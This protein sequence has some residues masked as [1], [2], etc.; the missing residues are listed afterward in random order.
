M[1]ISGYAKLTLLD[2]TGKF[3]YT[4]L[5][6]SCQLRRPFCHNSHLALANPDEPTELDIND[7]FPNKLAQLL[8]LKLID[9]VAMDIKNCL[10]RYAETCGRK[11][12]YLS[13]FKLIQESRI[14]YGF[15]TTVVREFYIREEF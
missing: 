6:P 13:V 9:Y 3:A 7:G 5:T 15:R 14:T 10:S 1:Q 11:S 2:Y 12:I 4:I 8:D